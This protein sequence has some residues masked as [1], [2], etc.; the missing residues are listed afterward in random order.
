MNS[1]SVSRSRRPGRPAG[2]KGPQARERLIDAAARHF[3]R[4]G[5]AATSLRGVARDAGVTPAM[6]AYY[7][8][9]KQGLLRAVLEAGLDRIVAAIGAALAGS[10]DGDAVPRFVR[11][12]LGVIN[13]HPWIPRI[14]VQEVIARDSPLRQVLAQRLVGEVLPLV[15]PAL[16]RAIALGRLRGDLDP[17]LTLLSLVGMSVFP[18][19]AEPVLGPLLGYATDPE[20]GALFTEHTVTVALRGLGGGT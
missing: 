13:S 19:I 6:V 7:F 12:Y 20:F 10:D 15:R 1:D 16:D 11:A 8:G 18:Y 17:R 9:D 3:S 5:F 4:E 2:D 14:L